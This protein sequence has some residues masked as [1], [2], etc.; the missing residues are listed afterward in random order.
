MGYQCIEL[1]VNVADIRGEHAIYWGVYWMKKR[2]GKYLEQKDFA[3]AF[4]IHNTGQ[5]IP[6]NGK[7][8]THDPN[9]VSKGLKYMDFF[10]KKTV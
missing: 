1:E 8:S 6:I 7:H 10:A 5:P 2:Y 3:N 4:H 9:Y